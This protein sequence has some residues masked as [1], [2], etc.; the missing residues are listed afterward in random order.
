[1]QRLLILAMASTCSVM[2]AFAQGQYQSLPPVAPAIQAAPYQSGNYAQQA[3]PYQQAGYG[4]QASQYQN[5]AP[6]QYPQVQYQQGGGQVDPSVPGNSSLTPGEYVMTNRTTGQNMYVTVTPTGQMY[7]Q[8]APPVQAAATPAIQPSVAATTAANAGGNQQD[9]AAT[10]QQQGSS[11]LNL[12]GS[13]LKGALGMYYQYKYG[14]MTGGYPM[15]GGGYGYGYPMYGASTGGG[16]LSS[17][18]SRF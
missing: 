4:Q 3:S 5:T 18:L 15:Y 7:T 13:A 6:A 1:M 8:D 9:A 2:P 11:K 12:V 14:G 17:V 16:F 10:T